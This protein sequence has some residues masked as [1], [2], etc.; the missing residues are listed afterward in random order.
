MPT[1]CEP[2]PGNISAILPPDELVGPTPAP[3][4]LRLD[5]ARAREWRS[6]NLRI[7]TSRRQLCVP[8]EVSQVS[9]RFAGSGPGSGC[10]P[11]CRARSHGSRPAGPL[12]LSADAPCTPASA[13]AF[14]RQSRAHRRALVAR[15]PDDFVSGAPGWRAQRV[16]ALARRRTGT[17]DHQRPQPRCTQ[18]LLVARRTLC[19]V[20]PGL[21]RRRELPRLRRRPTRSGPGPR[22]D[23]LRGNPC[24]HR[25]GATGDAP[26]DPRVDESAGSE[27]LRRLRPHPGLGSTGPRRREPGQR[28]RLDRRSRRG[29]ARRA[30]PDPGGRFRDPG[31]RFRRGRIPSGGR[32]RQRGRRVS[33]PASCPTARRCG[34][35]APATPT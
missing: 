3:T 11:T 2:W 28:H 1:C 13:R 23:A 30:R 29:S 20:R 32:V 6:R 35:A 26:P 18:L 7:G 16:G 4:V 22:P 17:A 31:A 19:P 25:G 14:L 33:S 24:G 15:R 12:A 34:S 21:R 9:R 27:R 10:G 5:S 8:V